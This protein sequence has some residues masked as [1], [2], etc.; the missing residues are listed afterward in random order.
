MY[1]WNALN[2]LF[3]LFAFGLTVA[4]RL[5]KNGC[6]CWLLAGCTF[7]DSKFGCCCD[8]ELNKFAPK[9]L[10]KLLKLLLTALLLICNDGCDGGG[11]GDDNIGGTGGCCCLT[12]LCNFSWFIDNDAPDDLDLVDIKLSKSI[13]SA[14]FDHVWPTSANVV[15][16]DSIAFSS[17][18]LDC[19]VSM[20]LVGCNILPVE[21]REKRKTN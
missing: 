20:L 14:V 1:H 10:F 21:N 5:P 13:L 3:K 16:F 17:S 18:T 11:G 19:G 2:W 6:C 7:P 12:G 9:L 15:G 4:I 8:V